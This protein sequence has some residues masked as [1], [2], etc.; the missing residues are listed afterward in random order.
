M[1]KALAAFVGLIL[2]LFS[3]G[4][5][6]QGL[7]DAFL[8]VT[9]LQYY[10]YRDMRRT[11]AFVPQHGEMRP[12]DS[13]SV[14][15]QGKDITHG[16]EGIE[17]ATRLGETLVNPQAADD[18]SIA[19]GQRKFMKTCIPCHG[20]TLAG[21]GPVA[22]LFMPPPDLLAQPTRE[23]KDGYIFSYMRHGGVVMPS[24]GAQVTPQEAWDV[25]NFIRH[26][27]KTSPR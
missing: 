26:M 5:V 20:P 25:V 19:R 4:S 24:Y 18:S 17:L 13:T 23:R 14:P 6:R 8:S 11:V 12:P 27:Q 22:A 3:L 1:L 15:I 9:H 10:P 7:N 21:N 2:V 16:L